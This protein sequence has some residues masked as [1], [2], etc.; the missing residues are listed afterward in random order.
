M[1]IYKLKWTKLQGEIFR[2]LSIKI[3]T[4]SN[5]RQIAKTLK[6]SPTA[7]SKSMKKLEKENIITITKNP[8]MNLLS[9]EL[10]RNNPSVINLKRVENLKMIYESGIDKVLFEKFQGAVII[11]FGSYSRGEDTIQSDIDIAIIGAKEKNIDLIKY[12]KLL[13]RTIIN[14]FYPSFKEIHKNLKDN[15]LNGIVLSGSIDL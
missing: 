15:I 14:N 3:G 11:L 7:I 6:V 2:Y 13:N 9:I 1:D 5:Q 8:T 12:N 10:N 4:V